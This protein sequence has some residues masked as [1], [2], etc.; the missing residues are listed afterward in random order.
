[1][2]RRELLKMIAAATGAAMIGGE[3]LL[4]G[5]KANPDSAPVAFTDE[6][7]AYLDEIAETIIPQTN[8]AGA[9]AA[10]VG[11]FMTVMVI[12]CYTR[13]DQEIFRK[14][15]DILEDECNKM[16]KVGFMKATPEQ[17][18]QLL[19]A[20]DK[21]TKDYVKRQA[22]AVNVQGQKEKQG[23]ERNTNDFKKQAMPNH[24]FQQLKQLA[25][26]GYFTSEKGRT[27]ALRYT[28]IPGK[29]EAVIDYK[30]GDKAFAG[31]T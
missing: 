28:P 20:V 7:I 13:E 23:Q 3:F 22:D 11:R 27:E 9:K 21:E 19:I 24:Y 25:I 30:K 10:G 31:L 15:L 29:F 8:T 2:N 16:H 18:K 12:D 17:R 26:F 1:M 4:T 5:C 6:N 14:G